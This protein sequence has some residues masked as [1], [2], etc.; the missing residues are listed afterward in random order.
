MCAFSGRPHIV[1]KGKVPG[2]SVNWTKH[3]EPYP[4]ELAQALA[5]WVCRSADQLD[6]C[7]L[8]RLVA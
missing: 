5:R 3:A 1:L 8:H 7:H 4:A 6:L 2:T